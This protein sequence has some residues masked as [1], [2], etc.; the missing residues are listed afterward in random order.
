MQNNMKVVGITGSL[1]MGKS[2]IAKMLRLLGFSVFDAD[3]T[4]HNLL[5]S[6][7]TVIQQVEYFFPN[8][9][10]GGR[11]NKKALADDIYGDSHRL[12]LLESIIHPF[13]RDQCHH[14][15]DKR[16]HK[17]DSLTFLDVPLLYEAGYDELCDVIWVAWCDPKIRL[18]RVQR[19]STLTDDRI[20]VI[21]SSQLS[22]DIKVKKADFVIDTSGSKTQTLKNVISILKETCSKE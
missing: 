21:I 20:Q 18:G 7:K 1:G 5:I 22:D 10:K 2:T 6:N 8:S 9:V 3:R 16:Q 12:K 14:F 13:V 4:V 19:R 17:G 15:L 11:V